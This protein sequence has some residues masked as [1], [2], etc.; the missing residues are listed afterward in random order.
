[1]ARPPDARLELREVLERLKKSGTSVR[2]VSEVDPVDDLNFRIKS[3]L[4]LIGKEKIKGKEMIYMI[5]YDISD[6]K[7]R[8][9]ISKY[10]KRNGCMRIQRSVFIARSESKRFSEIKEALEEV[11]DYYQNEDSI[12]LVPVN[13]SDVRSMKVLGKNIQLDTLLDPPNTLF[14]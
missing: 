6:N 14:F 8:H 4:G 12:I 3:I 10:L 2:N 11:N 9:Q 13:A 1:M 5:M 7:V